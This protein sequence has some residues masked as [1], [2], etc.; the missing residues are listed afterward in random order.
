MATSIGPIAASPT[1]R[2]SGPPGRYPASTRTNAESQHP[3]RAAPR[4]RTWIRRTRT[5]GVYPARREV[6]RPTGTHGSS[7]GARDR[8][9]VLLTAP[10]CTTCQ[11]PPEATPTSSRRR[12]GSSG[13]CLYTS[14]REPTLGGETA[15]HAHHLGPER[16]RPRRG[17]RGGLLREQHAHDRADHGAER[18]TV[19][20]RLTGTVAGRLGGTVRRGVA[21]DRRLHA[22]HDAAQDGRQAAH[23]PR[24][25]G[26]PAVL[27]A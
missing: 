10:R 17:P 8:C 19:N 7:P 9:R 6:P 11:L 18:R 20:R 5:G 27:P 1:R 21:G 13:G 4:I 3:V 25:P 12:F 2:S 14:A 23:G 22:G 26:L 16:P 15:T 24:Q